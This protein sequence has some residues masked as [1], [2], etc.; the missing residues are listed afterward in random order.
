M[1]PLL[2][3]LCCASWLSAPDRSDINEFLLGTW[4]SVIVAGSWNHKPIN[5]K[6]IIRLPCTHWS[7]N[8]QW[9]LQN[10][11]T[12]TYLY[13]QSSLPVSINPWANLYLWLLIYTYFIKRWSTHPLPDILS[14]SLAISQYIVQCWGILISPEPRLYSYST[15]DAVRIG[16]SFITILNYT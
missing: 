9:Y 7:N 6:P 11:P 12:A 3:L 13:L 15:Q 5:S 2:A 4:R 8:L 1:E 10:T 14:L 16:N